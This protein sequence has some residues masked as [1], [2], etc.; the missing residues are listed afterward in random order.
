[1]RVLGNDRGEWQFVPIQAQPGDPAWFEL[2]FSLPPVIAELVRDNWHD[3]IAVA[4]LKRQNFY[5]VDLTGVIG[6]IRRSVRLQ[7]DDAWIENYIRQ[8]SE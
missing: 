6:G 3:P 4:N 7:L 2:E 1:M 5:F 8:Q